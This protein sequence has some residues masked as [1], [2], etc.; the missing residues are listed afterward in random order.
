M[1]VQV[2][3]IF[4]HTAFL[5]AGDSHIIDHRQVLHIFAQAHTARVRP[6]RKVILCCHQQHCQHL[7]QATHAA[8]IDLHDVD[9]TFRD[10]LLEHDA[11]LA[12]F[13]GGNLHRTNCG[14]NLAMPGHIVGAGRFL[15]EERIGKGKPPHPLNGLIDFPHLVGVD[16]E[17]TVR[18]DNLSRDGQAADIVFQ[19][20]AHLHLD[21]VEAF[22]DRFLAKPAQFRVVIAKPA[23]RGRVAGIA[24][25]LQRGD[26]LC[27]AAFSLPQNFDGFIARQHIGQITIIHDIGDFFRRKLR[28][29]PPDRLSRLFRKQ[30]PDRVDHSA[31]GKVHGALLRADP[32]QL[33]VTRQV[34]PELAGG[35]TDFIKRSPH[36][37]MA[38]GQ[39]R[40]AAN[41]V[42]A[43][44]GEGK[45]VPFQ[46]LI[47]RIEDDIGRRIVRVGIHRIRAVQTL[48]RRKAQVENAQIGDFRHCVSIISYRRARSASAIRGPRYRV[49][50]HHQP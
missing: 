18:P 2:I 38:H 1:F 9:R 39:D 15:D 46:R 17:I 41:I 31:G 20:V 30:I 25:R 44:D 4:D 40:M 32:A 33:A 21:V 14:A 22:I 50:R 43:A 5:G 3:D 11:V 6:D 12:H 45:A 7:V 29:Q 36:D 23:S 42:T 8:A 10:K 49:P 28:D 48:R 13:A 26:T 24:L 19:I 35:G 37:Q 16:H 47:I 34:M 27:L